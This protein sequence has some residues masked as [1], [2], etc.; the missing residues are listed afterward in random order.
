MEV[1][2]SV[3]MLISKADSEFVTFSNRSCHSLLDSNDKGPRYFLVGFRLLWSHCWT[4]KNIMNEYSTV[5]MREAERTDEGSP[6]GDVLRFRMVHGVIL[7]HGVM[8]MVAH[9]CE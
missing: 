3:G 1:F 8:I 4:S 7:C 5:M 6:N 2:G 9:S